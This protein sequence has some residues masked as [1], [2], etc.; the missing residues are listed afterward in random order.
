MAKVKICGLTNLEDAKAAI[1]AGADFLGF[2]NARKSPRFLSAAKIRRLLD[3]LNPLVPTVLVTHS[4]GVKGI[5]KSFK[6]SGA[7]IL[8]LHARLLTEDYEKLCKEAH[9]S[10]HKVIIN[11][12]IPAGMNTPTRELAEQ[13]GEASRFADY[14]LF[15]TKA[16]SEIGGTGIAYDWKVA[17]A[18]KQYTKK[19][20]IIAGGLTPENV[21][22][23]IRAVRP[24]AVDV[25]SGV[26]SKTGKKDEA[27]IKRFI[28]LAK[29]RC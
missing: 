1:E 3:E 27:K 6:A 14:I 23:A 9:R 11:V 5:T 7:D 15:D 24:F 19:P 25:S 26:E 17:A 2:V 8:Q 12:S 20:V 28:R 16:G 22:D 21:R 10:A 13:V 4:T 18:L 29:G